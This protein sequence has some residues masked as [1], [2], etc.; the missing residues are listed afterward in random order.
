MICQILEAVVST[1]STGSH[2]GAGPSVPA[3]SRIWQIIAGA[4][5]VFIQK[6]W[7]SKVS[8]NDTEPQASPIPIDNVEPTLYDWISIIQQESRRSPSDWKT[9]AW[10]GRVF[11]PSKD[12]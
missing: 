12:L 5:L 10:T 1:Q 8:P 11:E 7:S 9:K 3:A 2:V 4:L 6:A